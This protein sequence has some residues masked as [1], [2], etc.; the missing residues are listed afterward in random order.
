MTTRRL[1]SDSEA[2][3]DVDPFVRRP[4]TKGFARNQGLGSTSLGQKESHRKHPA[5]QSHILHSQYRLNPS[6]T[7][8]NRRSKSRSIT[9]STLGI[10][11]PPGLPRLMEVRPQICPLRLPG[12]FAGKNTKNLSLQQES[13]LQLRILDPPGIEPGTF[14]RQQCS[15]NDIRRRKLQMQ[16]ENH[17]TRPQ[18]P[19]TCVCV[20]ESNRQRGAYMTFK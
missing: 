20:I 9:V 6:Q 5:T 2:N 18:A 3:A 1:V 17:T 14:H 13:N 8:C 4:M 12:L 11:L 7:K 16:S 10:S 15:D 19:G